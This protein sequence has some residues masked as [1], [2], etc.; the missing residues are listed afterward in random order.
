MEPLLT[1]VFQDAIERDNAEFARHLAKE[2]R[3]HESESIS[4][5]KAPNLDTPV[6]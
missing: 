2:I 3:L 4:S 6:S 1:H 5:E